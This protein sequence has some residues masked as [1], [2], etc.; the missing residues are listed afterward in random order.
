MICLAELRPAPR[1]PDPSR[2]D[3]ICLERDLILPQDLALS[4]GALLHPAVPQ[5]VLW[6]PH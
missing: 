2:G 3:P 1:G 4:S 5:S 6:G